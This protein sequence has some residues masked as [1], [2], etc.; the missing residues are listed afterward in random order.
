MSRRHRKRG[1]K[2][3]D[4]AEFHFVKPRNGTEEDHAGDDD[5]VVGNNAVFFQQLRK[6]EFRVN[7]VEADVTEIADEKESVQ[8]LG[9]YQRRIEGTGIKQ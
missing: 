4:L 8:I 3:P 5:A 9:R 6:K 2:P 7:I 1:R